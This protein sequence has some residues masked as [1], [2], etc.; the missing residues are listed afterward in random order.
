MKIGIS[1]G[2]GL[3][4]SKLTKELLDRDHE[5][6]IFTRNKSPNRISDSNLLNY[7]STNSIQAKDLE[8]LDVIFNLAG[9]NIAGVRW[10]KS[11]KEEFYK[12][13]VEYTK[14]LVDAI[15]ACKNPP[16][17]FINASAI[18]YYGA[19]PDSNS[20]FKETD[21]PGEDYLGQLCADWESATKGILNLKT[22]V[23]IARIGIVL[24]TKGGALAKLIPIF[25]AFLGGPIGS[26]KQGMSWI[27][28]QDLVN[29]FI[30]MMEPKRKN[31]IFNLTAPEPKS[32]FEFAKSLGK[33]LNRPSFFPTPNLALDA[34]FGEGSIVV[35]QGQFVSPTNLIEEG[36]HFQ[37]PDLDIAL[38]KLLQ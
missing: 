34:I 33:A 35:T 17:I 18:G 9:E 3:I 27:H 19:Y 23:R 15:N 11:A 28:S 6:Y 26:G 5:V 16:S 22:Q 30:F 32:N 13:R 7:I 38:K 25:K 21:Q 20:T 4:G 10:T 36:F 12:S 24:D 14:H 37:F 8:N 31:S 29:A 1:G 2:T